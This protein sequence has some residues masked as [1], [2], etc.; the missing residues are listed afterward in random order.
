M[1]LISYQIIQWIIL[2]HFVMDRINISY[3]LFNHIVDI[4]IYVRGLF[5]SFHSMRKH[6]LYFNPFGFFFYIAT[7]CFVFPHKS[8]RPIIVD[9]EPS[10]MAVNRLKW[11]WT[12]LANILAVNRSDIFGVELSTALKRLATRKTY[13]HPTCSIW[14]TVMF[15]IK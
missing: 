2:L 6:R 11:R 14:P 4:D 8:N 5:S 1:T 15:T 9:G 12:V 10:T 3:R 7:T 13:L